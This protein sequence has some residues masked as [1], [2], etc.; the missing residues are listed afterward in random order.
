M[1]EAALTSHA[2]G[3][4]HKAAVRKLVQGSRAFIHKK[5]ACSGREYKYTCNDRFNILL[6]IEEA[7]KDVCCCQ[8]LSMVGVC[9]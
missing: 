7:S 2:G 3:A 4:G 8:L 9:V 6:L 1:G 5:H